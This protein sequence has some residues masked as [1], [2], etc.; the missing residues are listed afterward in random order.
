MLGSRSHLASP[1]T[2]RPPSAV[3]GIPAPSA[4]AATS[5]IPVQQ[6]SVDRPDSKRSNMS[7]PAS[8]LASKRSSFVETGFVETLRPQ[9]IP[10]Q[11]M[12]SPSPSLSAE[13]KLLSMQLQQENE[14]LRGQVRDLSEKLET[15]KQRR[16]EDKEFIR[17]L[18]K[19]K[20]PY[21]QLQEF[22]QRIIEANS[23]LQRDL[24]GRARRP[25]TRSRPRTGT[26]RRCLTWPRTWR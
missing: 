6:S 16:A 20:T 26:R 2:E 24:R 8:S 25:R 15:I 1:A 12:T 18:E 14:D 13:E 9:F 7:P 21:E 3:S 17:E 4:S 5:H 10:G 22:K 23:Q 11:P 19:I